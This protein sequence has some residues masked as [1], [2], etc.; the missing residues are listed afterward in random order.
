MND[1][2]KIKGR[3]EF[4]IY[5]R[6]ESPLTRLFLK[7]VKALNTNWTQIFLNKYGVVRDSWAVDNLITS[8]GKAQLALLAGDASATPFTY[9]AVGTGNTSPAADQTTLSAEVSTSGLSRAAATVSR[10]NTTVTNDTLQLVV[11]WTVTGTVAVEEV[12][13][14]NAAS[15]GTMLGRAL[16]TTKNVANGETLTGTYQVIFA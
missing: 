16:T 15:S 12:G 3:Y 11:V 6:F 14:F 7:T 1:T 9:L 4:K 13:A 5:E 10:T 2:I 8:A